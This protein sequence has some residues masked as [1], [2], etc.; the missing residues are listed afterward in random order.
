MS[1]KLPDIETL[2]A[3]LKKAYDKLTTARKDME[4]GY[5]GDASS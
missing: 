3:M 5:F 2:R 1:E 4:F